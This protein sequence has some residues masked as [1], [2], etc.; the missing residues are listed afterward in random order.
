M[1]P[2]GVL[3]PFLYLAT[4]PKLA[5]PVS[6]GIGGIGALGRVDPP[7][8]GD[9]AARR[10]VDDDE[11]GGGLGVALSGGVGDGDGDGV[12][13]RLGVGVGAGAGEGVDRACLDGATVAVVDGAGVGVAGVGVGEGGA[14]RDVGTDGCGSDG[15]EDLG[16]RGRL[17]ARRC[18]SVEEVGGGVEGGAAVGVDEHAAGDVP[19]GRIAGNEAV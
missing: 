16:D 19:G 1:F 9:E 13:A 8:A 15:H 10:V 4:K 17:V 6:V 14:H 7:A 3:R 11:G 5:R 12:D 2:S 18:H